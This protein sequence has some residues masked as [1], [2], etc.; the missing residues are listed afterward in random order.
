MAA[1][2]PGARF[3][4]IVSIVWSTSGRSCDALG[5]TADGFGRALKEQGSPAPNTPEASAVQIIRQPLRIQ[6]Q[7]KP[8][9]KSGSISRQRKRK[10]KKDAGSF[11]E[12]IL[13]LMVTPFLIS[14]S[15]VP[16]MLA[17]LLHMLVKSALLG[18]IGLV[19]MLVNMFSSRRNPGAVTHHDLGAGAG[20]DGV[21]MA[22]YGWRGDEEY[23]AYVNRKKRK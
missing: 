8:D 19:L 12:R 10:R 16:A 15:M 3:V 22:H 13:P 5:S 18:K 17:S 21:A 1:M 20:A 7:S 2:L 9:Q 23:G 6:I 14:S 4:L 11:V